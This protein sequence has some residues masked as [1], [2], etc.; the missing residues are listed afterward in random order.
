MLDAMGVYQHHDAI[1][2][3]AKQ[4]VAD[5]YVNLLSKAMSKNNY[6]Y[7]K[8]LKD[9]VKSDLNLSVSVQSTFFNGIQN[10]TVAETPMGSSFE[11]ETEVLVVV[12]N[13]SG[14]HT[15]NHV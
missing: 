2:G 6:V 12:H 13:P 3:T 15:D 9:M 10:N 14:K 11:N 1:S 4:R 7:G 5:S 8:Y